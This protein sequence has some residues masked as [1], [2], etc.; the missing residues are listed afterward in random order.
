ME[1]QVQAM[2]ALQDEINAH[3][4]PDWRGQGYPWYRAIWVECA[5]LHHFHP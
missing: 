4:H 3:I 1:I 5:E 2:L